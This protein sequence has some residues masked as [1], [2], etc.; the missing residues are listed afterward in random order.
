MQESF[1]THRKISFTILTNL[2]ALLTIFKW[3]ILP[4]TVENHEDVS[5]RSTLAFPS[6]YNNERTKKKKKHENFWSLLHSLSLHLKMSSQ[7]KEAKEWGAWG[8][9]DGKG[10]EYVEVPF[11][12]AELLQDRER[13]SSNMRSNSR[14]LFINLSILLERRNFQTMGF[15]HCHFGVSYWGAR[16]RMSSELAGCGAPASLRTSASEKKVESD[17]LIQWAVPAT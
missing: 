7:K 10:Q 13:P 2:K 3:D 16:G 4:L 6:S 11:S 5:R 12:W 14:V 8:P 9:L 17:I 15:S 1:I